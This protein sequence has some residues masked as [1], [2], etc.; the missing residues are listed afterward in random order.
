MTSTVLLWLSLTIACIVAEG[1]YSSLEMAIVSFNKVRLQYYVSKGY[2]R[3]LW[4]N[5]LLQ[6][7]SR[8]LGTTLL[9]VN[10]AMQVG[11]ECSRHLYMALDL[12]ADLAPLTQVVL[13]LICAELAP[14]FAARRYSEHMSM[15]GVPLIYASA[16]IMT[17]LIWVISAISQLANRLVG[18]QERQSAMFLS[19][20]ELVAVLEDQA[21][22]EPEAD[23]EEL[24]VLVRNIFS[25]RNKV[26]AD[27]MEP[28]NQTRSLPMDATVGQMRRA[29]ADTP[30]AF[31][32]IFQR[33]PHNVI[34]IAIPR[35]YIKAT[36]SDRVG[37]HTRS[38]WFITQDS[39]LV[40]ILHQFRSNSQSVAV[41][42]DK[43]GRAVG[44]LTLDDVL[45]EV[46]GKIT[47]HAAAPYPF[48]KQAILAIDKNFSGDT[49]IADFNAQYGVMLDA[50]ETETFA[51][52]LEK[53][54]GHP[55][56]VNESIY[57]EPFR[58]TVKK[59]TLLGAKTVNVKTQVS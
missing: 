48:K 52:L 27:I 16:K 5:W 45:E 28:I 30:A 22:E 4:L 31:L 42:L 58:L 53:V 55:P 38:P 21:G 59:A 50:Q 44:I 47:G 9:G 23:S 25:L 15:L 46:F 1:F 34:G 49:K 8:L 7:P 2:R 54:L 43:P 41:V 24:N 13:V 40:Q 18:G 29:L 26:A 3:A 36:D 12:H 11:S 33:T 32:P 37:Q 17:P 14:G 57:I 20:D 19:R 35:D 56:S 39:T 6:H 10:I 51:E